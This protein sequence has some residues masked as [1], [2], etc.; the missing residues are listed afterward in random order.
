MAIESD[1]YARSWISLSIEV[2]RVVNQAYRVLDYINSCVTLGTS[3]RLWYRVV[4]S[5]QV[6]TNSILG[7]LEKT[8]A[9]S[10]DSIWLRKSCKSLQYYTIKIIRNMMKCEA[11]AIQRSVRQSLIQL[12]SVV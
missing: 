9:K 6:S 3:E 5:Q 12:L 1:Q 8:A 2:I 7:E 11:A 10:L 4:G